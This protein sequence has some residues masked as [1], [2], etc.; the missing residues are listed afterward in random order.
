MSK[1]RAVAICLLAGGF[2][3][4]NFVSS[5]ASGKAAATEWDSYV[6]GALERYFTAHPDDAV[7]AGRHEYDGKLPDVS[8]QGIEREIQRL[9]SERDRAAAF[10]AARLDD[11]RKVEREYV[12][13][14][15]DR[16]LF[17][18]ETAEGPFRTPT[19]YANIA[20]PDAYI[21]RPYAPPEQ[22]MRAYIAFARALPTVLEQA[23][24]NLR[25]P[26]PRSFVA[27][28]RLRFGGL[29]AF[30][31]DDVPRSFAAVKDADLL[32]EFS[33]A[34]A[35]AVKAAKDMDAWLKTLEG[36]ATESFA[37]GPEKFQRMLRDTERVDMPLDQLEAVGRRDLERNLASL[38]EACA[39]FAP[40][41]PVPDCVAKMS[42]DKPKRGAVQE[43]RAQLSALKQFVA[44]KGLVSIPGAEEAQVKEAPA[45]QRSNFAYINIPGPYEKGL[46]SIFYI[47]PPDPVWPK[48]ERD[49][50]VPGEKDLLFT[51][52]HEVWPGHFLQ[53]LHSNRAPS[54]F[55][56]VFVG[57]AFAEGWAH[58]VEE[59]MW[60]SGVDGGSA[61]THIGQLTNALLR[62]VR[63]LSALGLHTGR[64]TQSES[65]A[66]FRESAFQD[67]GNAR[68]QAARGTYDPAYLN[69]TMGK[70]MIMKLR[71]EWTASRGGKQAWREF[72]DKFLS[73]GGPPIPLIRA[74]MLGSAGKPL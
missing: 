70:L 3:G 24:A 36:S 12:M 56:Q 20:D 22:R 6:T 11:A 1:W 26:M 21:M 37:L 39:Q 45:Y 53:F 54:K 28:G 74:A 41:K 72:H 67:P 48:S 33:E 23:R 15:Q 59:M 2:A 31:K 69:Y 68:Q 60:E 44:T 25:T 66:M 51:T 27:I 64:M 8:R 13:A 34:N 55:G 62:D 4:C 10:D 73:Y 5:D 65:E 35:I 43:A 50:Y 49:A 32:K 16:Q 58:Y 14:E 19:F 9:R 47:A 57:Y 18:L 17:W 7:S 63:F 42:A 52:I 40:G 38:R 29:A 61:E 30:Y 71:D 46:P